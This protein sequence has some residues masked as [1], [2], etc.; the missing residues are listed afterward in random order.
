[1]IGIKVVSVPVTGF[2]NSAS[3]ARSPA[4]APLGNVMRTTPVS[5]SFRRMCC[6]SSKDQLLFVRNGE[7]K[8][9]DAYLKLFFTAKPVGKEPPYHVIPVS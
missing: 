7:Q 2:A 9:L 1:M 6:Y 3:T 8:T 5:P 4:P